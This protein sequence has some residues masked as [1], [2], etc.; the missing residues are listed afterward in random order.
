MKIHKVLIR[1]FSDE[2]GNLTEILTVFSQI[3]LTETDKDSTDK[4][5]N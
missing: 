1:N 3:I 4:T 2:R 5:I